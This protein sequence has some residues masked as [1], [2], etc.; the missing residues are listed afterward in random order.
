MKRIFILS[1]ILMVFASLVLADYRSDLAN[2][3]KQYSAGNYR[4]ALVLYKKAYKEHPSKQVYSYIVYIENKLK[5]S[6]RAREIS[7]DGIDWADKSMFLSINPI[8]LVVLTLPLHFEMCLNEGAA[9]GFNAEPTFFG[10]AGWTTFGLQVGAEYNFYFQKH[11]PNG[12]FAGPGAGIAYISANYSDSV[13][14]KFS[15]SSVGFYI[16]GHGGYRWIWENGFLV[17][18]SA[19][20]GF[21]MMSLS[22]NV[23]GTNE[24]LP[25]GGLGG[26]IGANIGYA[27]K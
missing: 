11:A 20:L 8:G 5:K 4:A 7:D 21:T 15:S 23:N 14:D 19:S 3:N 10:F 1:F 25:Y 26:G 16:N 12:W 9:L 2:A 13:G 6:S 17:D 24:S 27:W 22:V 18:V